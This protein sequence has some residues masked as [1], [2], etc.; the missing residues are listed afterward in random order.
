MSY[1][2]FPEYLSRYNDITVGYASS[3]LLNISVSATH[4]KKSMPEYTNRPQGRDDWQLIY[5]SDG[6]GYYQY[7]NR[8]EKLGP[9][10]LVIFRP[11]EPQQYAY[12]GEGCPIIN[13]VHFSGTA[14]ESLLQ[15]FQLAD[16]PYCYLPQTADPIMLNLFTKLQ[17]QL[18]LYPNHNNMCWSVFMEILTLASGSLIEEDFKIDIDL[19]NKYSGQ[20]NDILRDMQNNLDNHQQVKDYAERM[21]LS[22]SRFAHVFKSLT[23]YSPIE[24]KNNLRIESAK[25]LLIK[26]TETIERISI[27]LGY[28]SL[29]TFSKMFKRKTGHSPNMYRMINRKKL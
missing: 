6:Y 1:I 16:K 2:E 8:I 27:E 15:N 29:S 18:R 24:Y 26:S 4:T 21:H 22:P 12:Y 10:V 17:L 3:E 11:G 7:G 20:I 14:A 13:Y 9:N 25:H 19:N 23:G 28:D 5:L